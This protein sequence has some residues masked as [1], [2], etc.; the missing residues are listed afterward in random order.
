MNLPWIR[1]LLAPLLALAL[2]QGCS[3][4]DTQARETRKQQVETG[5]GKAA[6]TQ[7]ED[8]AVPVEVVALQRGTIEGVL[9]FSVN[10][11]AENEVSV[12]SEAARRVQELRVEEGDE[13]RKGDVLLRL[14]D[15]EQRANLAQVESELAKVQRE[16]ERQKRLHEQGLVSEEA[17]NN[18]TYEIEQ[19]RYRLDE[20]QRQLSYTEVRAP[21]NG[22]ITRRLVGLGDT[23][24]INQQLFDLVDFDSIVAR[25]FVPEKE[26]ERLQVGQPARVRAPALGNVELS[27]RVLRIAPVVDPRSGTVKV[28]VAIPRSPG[29]GLRPGLYVDVTLVTETYR[30]AVLV[31]KQALVYDNDQIYVFRLRDD[32][33]VERLLLEPELEDKNF[34]KPQAGLDAGDRLV[35][36]GQAG[37]KDQALVRL[38]GGGGEAAEPVAEAGR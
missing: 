29:V 5:G 19:L 13:V 7:A 23:V 32:L 1:A 17:Y 14:Q 24:T 34:V 27:G 4:S 26:L 3:N 10:L 33:R 16:Y 21:I 11:E 22:I 15:D 35:V 38:V 9:R 12:Y 37:L 8:A 36:A 6:A 31:P 20:A 25:I 2:V 30:D 18:A 28:T